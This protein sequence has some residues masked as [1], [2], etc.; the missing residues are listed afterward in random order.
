MSYL[1]ECITN[2]QEKFPGMFHQPMPNV[3]NMGHESSCYCSIWG[4]ML[5]YQC[6]MCCV[7]CHVLHLVLGSY[8]SN[9]FI[10]YWYTHSSINSPAMLLCCYCVSNVILAVL[11][12]RHSNLSHYMAV[13]FHVVYCIH[14]MA[15][16]FHSLQMAVLSLYSSHVFTRW[17]CHHSILLTRFTN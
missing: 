4:R 13:S 9:M 12:F 15:Y 3:H 5:R 1:Y 10:R 6:T 14:Q 7:I 11:S 17:Q 2:L 8:H 16:F